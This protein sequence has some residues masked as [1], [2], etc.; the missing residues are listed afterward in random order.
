MSMLVK[1]VDIEEKG[2]KMKPV[3]TEGHDDIGLR[4]G[5]SPVDHGVT[6]GKNG[7]RPSRE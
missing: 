7:G 1:V 3:T 5:R 4:H 6:G 2:S